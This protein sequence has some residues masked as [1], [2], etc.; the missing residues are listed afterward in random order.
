MTQY[1]KLLRLRSNLNCKQLA[2]SYSRWDEGS[3]IRCPLQEQTQILDLVIFVHHG[4]HRNYWELIFAPFSVV[5][6]DVERFPGL[7][8]CNE[9]TVPKDQLEHYKDVTAQDIICSQVVSMLSLLN[10]W[11]WSSFML[12]VPRLK[13]LCS[14]FE[15]VS[16][17]RQTCIEREKPCMN[18]W[19]P[20][21][22]FL[23]C[24]SGL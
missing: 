19:R 12:G 13:L 9:Y 2:R 14:N 4:S 22:I 16:T 8:F 1:W 5:P 23:V 11:A 3:C 7:Q 20:S 6:N 24:S 21:R 10:I 18:V 15:S 17:C